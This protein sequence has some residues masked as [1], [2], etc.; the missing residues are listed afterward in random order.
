MEDLGEEVWIPEGFDIFGTPVG[1][2]QFVEVTQEEDEERK[3]W[4]AIP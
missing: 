4:E 3:L 2:R 1:S